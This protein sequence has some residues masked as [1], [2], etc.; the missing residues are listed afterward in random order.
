MEK[1][2]L[3][4][5]ALYYPPENAGIKIIKNRIII[6][7]SG[8]AEN[9]DKTSALKNELQ[10]VFPQY[11]S[12]VVFTQENN[13]NLGVQAIEKWQIKGVKKII[14]VASGKGGVGNARHVRLVETIVEEARA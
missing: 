9:T 14:G 13:I 11:K 5:I 2:I 1:Q 7:I 8:V 10:T 4:I 12:S 6:E 3:Q